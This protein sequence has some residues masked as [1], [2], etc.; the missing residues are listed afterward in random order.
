MLVAYT[1]NC[2]NIIDVDKDFRVWLAEIP[3]EILKL[4]LKEM[5]ELCLGFANLNKQN[6][7][8]NQYIF[9]EMLSITNKAGFLQEL[10]EVKESENTI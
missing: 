2:G 3:V 7:V 5:D 6:C 10:I 1:D 9:S 4:V 8:L